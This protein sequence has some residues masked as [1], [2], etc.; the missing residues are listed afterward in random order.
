MTGTDDE[1][2]ALRSPVNSRIRKDSSTTLSPDII[3]STV[4]R[5][6]VRLGQSLRND[7]AFEFLGKRFREWR[8]RR[9]RQQDGDHEGSGGKGERGPGSSVEGRDAGQ[10]AD[11]EMQHPWS[12]WRRRS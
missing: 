5:H 10:K 6:P 1:A 3:P 9:Q 12:R 11:A 4:L 2:T 7:R 8:H